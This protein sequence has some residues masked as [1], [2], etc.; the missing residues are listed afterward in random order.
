MTE[1]GMGRLAAAMLTICALALAQ[2]GCGGSDNQPAAMSTPGTD[3]AMT[4]TPTPPNDDA[5]LASDAAAGGSLRV[6]SQPLDNIVVGE[7]LRYRVRTSDAH[8]TF[9]GTTLP[10]GAVLD[11]AGSLSWTPKPDQGGSNRFVLRATAGGESV[12]QE[13]NVMVAAPRQERTG[14]VDPN[15]STTTTLTVDAPLSAIRGAAVQIDP[16][17]VVSTDKVAITISSLD[18]APVPPGA[19]IAGLQGSLLTPIELGPSGTAFRKPARVQL[20]VQAGLLKGA[21]PSVLTLDPATGAWESVKVLAIDDNQA[22]VTAEI[23]HFS[24]YVVVPEVQLIDAQLAKGGASTGCA[25]SLIVRAALAMSPAGL[26]ADTINGYGGDATNL[27]GVLTAMKAGQTLQVFVHALA[28]GLAASAVGPESGWILVSAS[29]DDAGQFKIVV[30]SD[31][32]PAPLLTAG[33]FGATDPVFLAMLAGRKGQFIFNGLGDLSAGASVTVDLSL[34]LVDGADAGIPPG[35]AVNPVA[36]ETFSNAT[37]VNDVAGGAGYDRDCDQTPDSDDPE[38]NGPPLPR[39]TATPPGPLH[40]WVGQNLALSVVADSPDVTFVWTAS[41][42]SLTLVGKSASQATVA[43]SR[44][45][46]FQVRVLGQRGAAES[47]LD[48]DIVVDEVVA[49]FSNTPPEVQIATSSA[50]ARVGET[51]ALQAIG[52]D[53][54]Q[55]DLQF[56]WLASDATVLSGGTGARMAFVAGT[57]GDFKINCIA[58][59]G[60]VDSTPAVV[61]LTVLPA[62]TNRPP[63]APLVSP[64][65]ALLTHAPGESV[66]ITLQASATDPDGD[67]VTFDFVPDASVSRAVSLTKNNTTAQFKTVIDG[68]FLFHVIAQ[69]SHGATSP[70]TTVSIQVLP[71]AAIDRSAADA[72]K[73]GYP[74]GADCNDGDAKVFPGSKEICGDGIDQDCDGRDLAGNDCDAD[75][76]RFSTTQGDCDDSDPAR[77]PAGFERCDGVDNDCDGKIDEGFEIGQAC[78]IGLGSCRAEGKTRCSATFVTVV[79]DAIPGKP[80]PETCDMVDNDCN[81]R[82]DDVMVSSAGSITSCGSCGVVCPAPAGATP[83]CVNGGCVAKCNPGFIDLDRDPGNGCECAISNGGIEACDGSDND[84]N[85]R[86]DDGIT[87][88][89]YPGAAGTA[90]V[91]VCSGGSLV[92]KA[93][94]LVEDR[95]ARLPSPEICDGLDNDCNGKVDESF[96]LINDPR[97]CGGCGI[98]CGATGKC[99]TGKCLDGSWDGGAPPPPTGSTGTMP[100]DLKP[101]WCPLPTGMICVDLLTSIENCGGCGRACPVGNVCLKASCLPKEQLPDGG[102]PLPGPFQCPPL[103]P[104]VDGGTTGT[105]TDAGGPV[106][107]PM[108]AVNQKLCGDAAGNMYCSDP[109]NDPKNC[110]GCGIFCPPPMGC[111]QGRC[112]GGGTLPPPDGGAVTCPPETVSCPLNGGGSYCA[113]V[114]YDPMNCGVCGKICPGGT[115]CSEGICLSVTGTLPSDAGTGPTCPAALI[116]CKDAAGVVTCVDLMWDRIH[117]GQCEIACPADQFCNMGRCVLPAP[118]SDGGAPTPPTCQPGAMPCKTATGTLV[119]TDVKFDPANCGVCGKVCPAT[120]SCTNGGCNPL[121]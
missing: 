43:P 31:R 79:C 33:P 12:T 7:T 22:L 62:M 71:T 8:A 81:G 74:A 88:A 77:N 4:M 6:L 103:A 119:C 67:G 64:L 13:F 28:R 19:R 35:A 102:V 106:G 53:R 105:R 36:R 68:V 58:S 57:P 30:R 54:E 113:K 121:P 117:C 29:K 65:S 16:G 73:D 101:V 21:R 76:D 26:P 86:V 24:T 39:L 42:P 108:C 114:K 66:S 1:R 92:C 90:G 100:G 72:D 34:Y 111:N 20:P 98:V 50:V 110:G 120:T 59:D 56:R 70:A 60:L 9:T 107:A 3:A 112:G 83:I 89:N 37:L 69:D 61:V 94:V 84:C 2:A 97:N 75:G 47:R 96:D 99:V 85:G 51:V 18:N 25:E 104:L 80:A 91:G 55:V 5:A 87:Q 49:K 82:V 63:E 95:A 15:D 23:Q 93:G 46:N 10:P 17:S 45:G 52:R 11:D 109:L 32:Q 118:P 78:A 40:L 48:W 41:D 115:F 14:L 27:A 44:A 116:M 38:P